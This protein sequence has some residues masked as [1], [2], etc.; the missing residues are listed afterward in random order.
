MAA[1]GS[2]DLIVL[3]R[4]G[5]PVIKEIRRQGYDIPLIVITDRGTSRERAEGLD[6]GADDYLIKPF[7]R[8][9]L[10]AR[11]RA[12]T[13]RK[14]KGLIC[15]KITVAG[16][17]LAPLKCE[18]TR[19]EDVIQLSVK[20]SLLLELLM[21]N[22]GQVV[23]KERIFERVWGYYSKTEFGYVELYIHYLR[24]KLKLSNIITVRGVGY[25]LKS[26]AGV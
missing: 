9:E 26:E 23:T 14:N 18:V 17:T 16:L 21:R 15:N 5:L 24:K 1:N 6:L 11:L 13:R 10:L 8:E 3:D 22:H 7:S 20:E 2:Y 4:D 19:G 25:I 12:L